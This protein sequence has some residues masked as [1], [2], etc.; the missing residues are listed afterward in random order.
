MKKFPNNNDLEI[1]F[2]EI[3]GSNWTLFKE[4]NYDEYLK[5]KKQLNLT[6]KQ[7]ETG[8]NLKHIVFAKYLLLLLEAINK[9]K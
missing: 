8:E 3:W 5:L 2:K 4:K 9:N 6:D 7:V 1:H